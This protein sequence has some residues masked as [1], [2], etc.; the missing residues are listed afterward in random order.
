MSGEDL[1]AAVLEA[2]TDVEPG[3][4]RARAAA[5][6]VSASNALDTLA[7]RKVSVAG[8]LES[9]AKQLDRE[10]A[11]AIPAAGALG[12]GGT[13]AELGALAA[14][15]AD[16]EASVDLKVACADAAGKIMSRSGAPAQ[17]L[18]DQLMAIVGSDADQKLRMAVV[19]ALG[20]ARLSPEAKLQLIEAL[21]VRP[22][23]EGAE[24]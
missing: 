16:D 4:Q 8:A 18:L 6:A 19:K 23:S 24:G 21:R 7:A 11:V 12:D 9:L 3:A 14:A 10:D 17:E 2:L 22:A 5:I 20:R 15:L 13:A 1:K